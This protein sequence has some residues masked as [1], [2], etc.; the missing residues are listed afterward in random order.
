MRLGAGTKLG[1]GSGAPESRA[2]TPR[3]LN[4]QEKQ[5]VRDLVKFNQRKCK[6]QPLG[7]KSPGPE[8]ARSCLTH[9]NPCREGW[10]GP[11]GQL[12]QEPAMFLP[13]KKANSSLGCIRKSDS[14]GETHLDWW[15]LNG[16]ISRR[17]PPPQLLCSPGK[18]VPQLPWSLTTRGFSL[19]T[20]ALLWPYTCWTGWCQYGAVVPGTAHGGIHWSGSSVDP[21][22]S[23]QTGWGVSEWIC[24]TW[25]AKSRVTKGSLVFSCCQMPASKRDATHA[26][27]LCSFLSVKQS[28]A[29]PAVQ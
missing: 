7:W 28:D 21:F 17:V 20:K 15:G 1:G 6:V 24:G 29:C 8:R 10:G 23:E 4:R 27:E 5:A 13:V 22:C 26:L 12:W 14:P 25:S 16:T 11:G 18:A 19:P 9:K 3:G 2:D